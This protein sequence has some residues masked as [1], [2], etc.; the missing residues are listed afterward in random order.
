M[1]EPALT[2]TSVL[3]I[4]VAV[5]KNATT[6]LVDINVI[7]MMGTKLADGTQ[8]HALISTNAQQVL[9]DVLTLA[10]IRLEVLFVL[11]ELDIVWP[12]IERRAMTWTSVNN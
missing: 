2:I 1:E 10:K 6:L 5:V 8:S 3:L 7:V 4:T 9:Q 11:V 12:G